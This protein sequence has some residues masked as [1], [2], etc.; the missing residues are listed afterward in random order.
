MSWFADQGG[1]TQQLGDQL[2]SCFELADDLVG[3][4]A[5]SVHDEDLG[6][7]MHAGSVSGNHVNKHGIYLK[8]VLFTTK[9]NNK[10]GP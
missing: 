5:D 7:L 10:K 6:P 1:E 9:M 2:L 3:C 8:E 4:L